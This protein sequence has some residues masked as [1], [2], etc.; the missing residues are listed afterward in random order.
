MQ[1]KEK[2]LFWLNLIGQR[3]F[4]MPMQR[5]LTIDSIKIIRF[6]RY[7]FFYSKII[8]NSQQAENIK[9]R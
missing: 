6:L 5:A 7:F 4:G 8:L 1:A 2:R 3:A 9:N